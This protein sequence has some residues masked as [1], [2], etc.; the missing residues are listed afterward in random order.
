MPAAAGELQS[1]LS[2]D[3]LRPS[4][5]VWESGYGFDAQF[6]TWFIPYAGCSVGIG[7]QI[8][9]PD[10]GLLRDRIAAA[11]PGGLDSAGVTVSGRTPVFLFGPS[12]WAGLRIVRNL[13][14]SVQAGGR[15]AYIPHGP[16]VHGARP[17][18]GA[19]P[20]KPYARRIDV[21]DGVLLQ[22]GAHLELALPASATAF[23]GFASQSAVTGFEGRLERAPLGNFAV[24]GMLWRGGFRGNW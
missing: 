22:A 11:P 1:S 6:G 19:K 18:E 10:A 16:L 15:Y 13:G 23:L 17:A 4:A 9:R 14:L 21:E 24:Q 3:L 5:G 8:A 7:S 12:L 2:A 20:P